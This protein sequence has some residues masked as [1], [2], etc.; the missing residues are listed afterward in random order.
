MKATTEEVEKLFAAAAEKAP[1]VLPLIV[2][3]ANTGC[4]KG[5]ALALT[6]ESVDL[7]RMMVRIW[8]NE[9]W[10]PKDNDPREV[11]ISDALLPWLSTDEKDR[12]SKKWVFPCPKTKG[13]YAYWP[14]RGFDE[15]RKAAGLD[16][17]P[18]TLRH[19]YASHFLASTPDLFLLARVL[20]HSDTRVTRLYAHLLPDHLARARDAVSLAPAVGPATLKAAKRWKVDADALAGKTVPSTVPK[21]HRRN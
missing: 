10:Q 20:G 11:P 3:L 8:P 18:H 1:A 12:L 6:W 16:G 21:A 13:R 14:K 2:F 4:R 17:G 15:A 7:E 9:D 5:E 19:T